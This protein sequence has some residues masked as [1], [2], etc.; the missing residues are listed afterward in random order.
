MKSILV[1]IVAALLVVGCGKKS[2]YDKAEECAKSLGQ[3]DGY[4]EMWATAEKK[5]DGATPTEDQIGEYFK[6]G[7]RSC[8][9]GGAYTIGAVQGKLATCSIH[10]T[11]KDF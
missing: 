3:I 5:A 6:G 4:K 8:P 2:E 7:M 11:A 10:G 9:S 1:S